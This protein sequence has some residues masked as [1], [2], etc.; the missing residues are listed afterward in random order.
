MA[1]YV[2]DCS[3]RKVVKGQY[4][5]TNTQTGSLIAHN[6]LDLL[7]I[8]FTKFDLSR[9][10]KED[11]LVLTNAFLKFNQAFVIPNQKAITIAVVLMDKCSMCMEY[12]HVYIA[13]KAVASKMK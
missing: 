7:C 6:L 10:S 3:H 8:D 2:H 11:E 5:G 4:T 1:E 9:D 12:Q 13:T